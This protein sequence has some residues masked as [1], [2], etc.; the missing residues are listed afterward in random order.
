VARAALAEM[1]ASPND[2][3]KTPEAIAKRVAAHAERRRAALAWEKQNPG[4]HDLEHFRREIGPGLRAAVTAESPALPSDSVHSLQLVDGPR[5]TQQAPDPFV[6]RPCLTE[7]SPVA[8]IICGRV[9][10]RVGG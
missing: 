6:T 1:R 3:A 7:E 4:P 5:R 10:I 2:P 8:R 9:V